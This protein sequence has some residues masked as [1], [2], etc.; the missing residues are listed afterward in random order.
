MEEDEEEEL[1]LLDEEWQRG[2][3][4]WTQQSLLLECRAGDTYSQSS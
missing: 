1:R 4:V 3:K 2:D